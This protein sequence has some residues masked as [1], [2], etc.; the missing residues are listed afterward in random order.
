ME[1][2]AFAPAQRK[3]VVRAEGGYLA[4]VPPPLPPTLSFNRELIA[5]LSAADRAIGEL[6]GVGRTLPDS[7]ILT[8]PIVRR[9]AVLSSRI[10]GTRA[11]VDQLALFELDHPDEGDGDVREVYNYLAALSRVLAPDRRLPLS[12]PL[13]LEAHET[14]LNGVRGGYATPG[15]FRR[16]QNWI[17]PPGSVINNATYVPPPPERLWD[18]LGPFE[19][20][21]HAEHE[22]PPLV[23][24][25]CLHYQFEAIHPFVDGNGRVGRLLI[26]LLLID[27]NL[28]PAPLLDISAYIEPRRDE[29]YQR[30]LAVS[31]QG[32]WTGWLLFFLRAV[33][34]QATDA[35][36]RA[37]AL[38][39]LREDY[40][41]RVTTARASSLLPQLVDALFVTPGLTIGRAQ[42]LLNVS[43][44]SATLTVERLVTAGLLVEVRIGARRYFLA[45][46]II[47]VA[48]GEASTGLRSGAASPRGG[49]LR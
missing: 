24:I 16:S 49:R 25:G 20:Y 44:R 47:E 46:E 19:K 48:N 6:A 42:R 15:E 22:L 39:R 38:Q 1:R 7:E 18:C 34:D 36:S 13:L 31:T 26:I 23:V 10:E 4:F 5:A 33:A 45:K 37:R 14:L 9:E 41:S 11:S 3:H 21:L 43:R 8:A 29:Y 2:D 40:R 35:V 32:D 17:G 12:V 27:W 28:L 30:L